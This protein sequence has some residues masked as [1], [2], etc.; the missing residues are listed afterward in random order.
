MSVIKNS[1]LGGLRRK[2]S[3]LGF[4]LIATISV[5]VLLAL[6]AVGLLSLSS[7]SMRASSVD[8]DQ[9]EARANARMALMLAIDE[10]QKSAGD[11][12]RITADGSILSASASSPNAIGV[13]E[14]WSPKLADNPQGSSPDYDQEKQD[15][16]L[17]WLVSGNEVDLVDQSWAISAAAGDQVDLFGQSLDGFN[18][19]GGLVST[20]SNTSQGGFAWAV[21]QE[22]TKAKV[23]VAGPELADREINDDLYVQPRPNVGLSG[24][25][26]QPDDEW[27]NR[28]MR[29]TGY[30]QLELDS[31]LGNPTDTETVG[32]DFTTT[33]YGLLTNAVDGG[34]KVDMSLGFE[35]SQADYAQDSWSSNGETITNPFRKNAVTDF[36]IPASYQTQR[37]LYEPL[38]DSGAY[39]HERTWDRGTRDSVHSYFPVTAVPTFDTLRSFYRIPR[40]LYQTDGG[41]TVF[42][43][44]GDHIAAGEGALAG[45]YSRPP[46]IAANGSVTQ[47]SIRPVLDRVL[48]VYSLA[49]SDQNTPLYTIT[50]I[51]TLW[52]PYNVA[53]EFGGAVTYPWLDLAIHR[54]FQ[55]KSRGSFTHS[56]HFGGYLSRDL[57]VVDGNSNTRQM[58]PYVIGAITADGGPILGRVIPIRFEP[59]EVRVFAPASADLV[60]YTAI[61]STMRDRTI[62][63]RPVDSIDDYNI[64]GGFKVM[65][66]ENGNANFIM[67]SGDYVNIEFDQLIAANGTTEFPLCIG[68]G[69]TTLAEGSNPS[70]DT[71]GQVIMDVLASQYAKTAVNQGEIITFKSPN[72]TFSQLKQEPAPVLSLEVYH[73]V[74]QSGT[75]TQEADLMYTGNPRQSSM[76]PIVAKTDFQAG[77]QYKVRMR[78]LSSTNDLLQIATGGDRP[79]AYYGA[80]QAASSGRTHLSFFEIPRTPLLSLA[81]LQHVDLS[82][83]PYAPANQFG[84]S[85]ASAYVPRDKVADGND[86]LEVDHSYLTNEALWDG[87]FFS[88]AAP[89]MSPHANSGAVGLWSLSIANIDDS[90][91]DVLEDFADDPVA[92]PL[93][94][95][96]MQLLVSSLKGMTA[97]E[98]ATVMA[99]PGSCTK[100]AGH[101]LVDGS[102]NINSTSNKAW[103]ALLRG[104]H[105]SSFEL[106]DDSGTVAVSETPFPRFRDPLGTENDNWQGFRSLTD[107]QIQE[108]ATNIVE[109]VR[110]RGPFLSLAEFVNRRVSNDALGLSGALQTAIDATTSINQAAMQGTLDDSYYDG[111]EADNIS[112]KD[113]G[114]GIPG[115]LTQADLLQ[116]I[117]SIIT[118]RSDTFTI[119]TYGEAR[120][121]AGEITATARMEA[122]VQRFPEFVDKN[123]ASYTTM[124]ALSLQ[125]QALGRK[126][127]IVSVRFL[128]AQED[129]MLNS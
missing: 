9:L 38:V 68:F 48:Y 51:V 13:W 31:G 121:S 86:G 29:V 1:C 47:M 17:R 111:A 124:D 113:T 122:T 3:D 70:T 91:E 115:Y 36:T 58:Q 10:L 40:H 14:S 42:E 103:E 66:K 92:N 4:A 77:P 105:G 67:Q 61:G 120:D 7:V 129:E 21:S 43:R 112:P 73:R 71:R 118:P 11:D 81:G 116:S 6:V 114:V 109:Q 88:S 69:D 82:P 99:E 24:V 90:L 100:I 57:Q 41:V 62:F 34:L 87:W 89:T 128:S 101:L 49:L 18:L 55:G 117:A 60:D 5:L 119:R 44:E 50:P 16:F 53:L 26:T 108:L 76:N 35:M 94:N 23:N 19:Q 12:R 72:Y 39:S 74:A 123:D 125:N 104:L 52:N 33:S 15:R 25:F 83:T 75:N 110:A 107:A 64:T 20:Q 127:R 2:K 28:A 27:N 46:H 95:S 97:E 8:S 56:R 63:M 30:R 93:R 65:P 78:G 106:G 45:G 54:R 22:N 96:R 98:F 85:W 84:N 80:S 37:P 126:F 59:G 32:A 79:A 102:F